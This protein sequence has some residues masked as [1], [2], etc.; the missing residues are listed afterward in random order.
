MHQP[1]SGVRRA[2]A[3]PLLQRGGFVGTRGA[4]REG[5]PVEEIRPGDV[6]TISGTT[7][8]ETVARVDGTTGL[9]ASS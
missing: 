5:G 6:V 4:Q 9:P 8:R 2:T 3:P 7:V 1:G